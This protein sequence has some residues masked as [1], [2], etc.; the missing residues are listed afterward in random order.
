MLDWILNSPVELHEKNKEKQ[1][2]LL[3]YANTNDSIKCKRK[4]M[5]GR[6][7]CLKSITK[8]P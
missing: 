5:A 4:P 3:F 8:T 7:I 1:E 6:E 2:F